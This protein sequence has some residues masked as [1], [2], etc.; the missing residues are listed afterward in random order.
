MKF[1]CRPIE[2]TDEEETFEMI[3]NLYKEDP[4]NKPMTKEKIRNTFITLR[5]L[6]DKGCIMVIEIDYK[7]AGYSILINFHSNEFGGNIVFIDELYVKEEFRSKGIG[8]NFIRYLKDTKFG[9]AVALQL[10]VT[11]GNTKARKLY[12]SLG[13]Q[14]HK[15]DTLTCEL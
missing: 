6:P 10:E 1:T 2:A 12:E 8:T 3:E 4:V 14:L 5:S 9:N 11:P 15:N 13:F 7:I